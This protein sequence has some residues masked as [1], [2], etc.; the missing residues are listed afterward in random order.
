[1][2]AENIIQ[3]GSGIIQF[4]HLNPDPRQQSFNFKH[5][6]VP[7]IFIILATALYRAND[8]MEVEVLGNV[9]KN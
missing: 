6:L 8:W 3:T 9:L 2:A 5:P 4:I 7:I 1:M